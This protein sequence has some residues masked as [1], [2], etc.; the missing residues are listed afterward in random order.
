MKN[1]VL[2]KVYSLF[3][4][5][6]AIAVAGLN[7]CSASCLASSEECHMAVKKVESHCSA[8]T[9]ASKECHSQPEEGCE[10]IHTKDQAVLYQVTPLFQISFQHSS[11]FQYKE[12]FSVLSL[13]SPS[14]N[15]VHKQNDHAPPGHYLE[16]LISYLSEQHHAPP[17]LV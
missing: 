2:K 3:L 14:V 7:F 13:Y 6:V 1:I 15:R 16:S 9:E 11:L 8:E 4:F 17:V 5:V 10:C 12:L